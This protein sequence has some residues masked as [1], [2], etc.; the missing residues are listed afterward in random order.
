M[1]SNGSIT[2][3]QH[4]TIF[5]P[6]FNVKHREGLNTLSNDDVWGLL[7]ARG[8]GWMFLEGIQETQVGPL[9]ILDATERNLMIRL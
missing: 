4:D 9:P 7:R 5:L 2:H 6:L 1:S 8:H 3:H